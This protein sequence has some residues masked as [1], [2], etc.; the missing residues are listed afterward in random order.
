MSWNGQPVAV[1]LAATQEQADHAKHLI[2]VDYDAAPAITDLAAA[3][4]QGTET[5][6]F[7]GEK[8]HT[9]IG[10][11][12]AALA[13]AAFKADAT[14][15]TPRHNHNAIEPH[16]ATVAWDGDTL[17]IHD[18]TQCVS[19]TAWSIAQVFGIDE[20]Q[21]RVTSP[22]V[23]G[24]FGSKTLWQHQILGAAAARLAGRPVRIA[25]S[26]EGVYRTVGGRG[27]TEQRVAIGADN[28]GRFQAIIHTGTV[29]MT[30]HNAMPEPF[31]VG[32]RSAYASE[33]FKLDVQVVRLDT[34]ATTFMR[35]PGEAVGTFG[36]ECAIDELA[37]RIG[38]DP[39]ELRIRNEPERDPTTGVAFSQ[40][41]IV[42]AWRAGAARFGWDR[43]S[44]PGTRREGEWLVGLGCA[45]AT[46]PY[47][48]M[49][50]GAARITLSR[51]GQATV[52]IAAHEM[53]MGTAT[54]HTQVAAERLGLAME[55]VRV[56][57][58]DSA[59]PGLVLAGGS[60]QTASIGAAVSVAQRALFT[61]L[62]KLAGNASPLAGLKPDE[63]GGLDAG[64][65]KLD[66]PTCHE[67]YASILSRAG[68]ET[69]VVEGEAPRPFE[70]EHWSMHSHGAMFC[71]ARV[72]AV[73]GETRVSRFLGSFDCG[74]ILNA[75]TAASQF[76]G[77]II[78]GL[79]LALMEET[80]LDRRNGRIMN[81]SLAE[82]HLPVHGDVP[83]I[84]VMWND[85]A[86]PHAPM[87]ARGIGEI[88]ITGTGAAVANAV[89]NATGRRVRDLPITPEKLL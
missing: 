24:G 88:G 59:F 39:I 69:V 87:G 8:L 80:Q 27:L 16:A 79:G 40:R 10:D 20:A 50:G 46:Y 32:S 63:V 77:G 43:R 60:Q 36:L 57:Y 85:I 4:V 28:D 82:Y 67:S 81:P 42:A 17:R 1:V 22:Y 18:A 76:R 49:P 21:V 12:D 70:T 83:A 45:T 61:E 26:R 37:E 9:V 31:I 2:R 66:D 64:L 65:G 11:A 34:I 25:L 7:M 55:D 48:R 53:G 19:H 73:T 71:E 15:T 23:G 14:Y 47:Y 62:L 86:D 51:D 74:R 52:E 84:E 5:A 72:N 3:R 35:A 44:R 41:D 78:M 30:P 13:G 89:F 6:E 58:G 68:R 54:A 56:L 29:A 33:S 38:M 75:K